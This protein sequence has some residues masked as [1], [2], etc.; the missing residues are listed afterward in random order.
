MDMH[1]ET[2]SPSHIVSQDEGLTL[3]F[4]SQQHLVD[5]IVGFKKTV[6]GNSLFQI[7]MHCKCCKDR[8]Y[9][10]QKKEICVSGSRQLE[11]LASQV[12]EFYL[13]GVD[14]SSQNT[15]YAEDDFEDE[16]LNWE[17]QNVIG[18]EVNC[19][20][21]NGMMSQNF[22]DNQKL[23]DGSSHLAGQPCG[24]APARGAWND[25]YFD[26][27]DDEEGGNYQKRVKSNRQNAYEQRRSSG[28]DA[29]FSANPNSAFHRHHSQTYT[30]SNNLSSVIRQSEQIISENQNSM[31]NN[32]INNPNS[33]QNNNKSVTHLQ[34][35]MSFQGANQFGS[36]SK[37]QP[38]SRKRK[39]DDFMPQPTSDMLILCRS[40]S[41]NSKQWQCQD[42]ENQEIQNSIGQDSTKRR[43]LNYQGGSLNNQNPNKSY[44]VEIKNSIQT[45]QE[46]LRQDSWGNTLESNNHSQNM[47]HQYQQ[48]HQNF[49]NS[50]EQQNPFSCL[51][52]VNL[53]QFGISSS[54][55]SMSCSTNAD[56]ANH[57]FSNNPFQLQH[58]Q[59][60]QQ[61]NHNHQQ[62]TSYSNQ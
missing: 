10:F 62:Q 51:K 59:Q 37:V 11:Q 3:K 33:H 50:F 24:S 2:L 57:N 31:N 43:F 53:F 46:S 34:H 32:H 22:Q 6:S 23:I 39:F 25:I 9:W 7:T 12:E 8:T 55:D 36:K 30:L 29:E 56:F 45:K 4:N 38:I 5:S 19:F 28:N 41:D 40:Q 42:A 26:F 61:Q 58:Q 13:N 44:Y 49:T 52:P 48:H 20:S 16:V 27:S 15:Y 17:G 14:I 35:S 60:N 47:N 54:S 1:P 21:Q 18:T